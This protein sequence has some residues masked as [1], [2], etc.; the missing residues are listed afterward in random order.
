MHAQVGDWLGVPR[1][2][3]RDTRPA[4]DAGGASDLQ[5]SAQE[6]SHRAAGCWMSLVV[7][8][9]QRSALALH[10]VKLLAGG[11]ALVQPLT[12]PGNQG[13]RRRQHKMSMRAVGPLLSS[14]PGGWTHVCS[15]LS[16]PVPQRVE[17]Q[18]WRLV[19]LGP[20]PRAVPRRPRC[21]VVSQPLERRRLPV[22]VCALCL[23]RVARAGAS[24][25]KAAALRRP[26]RGVWLLCL[27]VCC[28]RSELRRGGAV[29]GVI[30]QAVR[31]NN[32]C[33]PSNQFPGRGRCHRSVRSP[34]WAGSRR[35]TKG[36][37]R[38]GK[39]HFRPGAHW[40]EAQSLC[41]GRGGTP[42]CPGSRLR[43]LGTAM[44]YG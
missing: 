8:C 25:T 17:T 10:R 11:G 32:D 31:T 2:K 6:C 9:G 41:G 23:L 22:Y 43:I 19:N 4:L 20:A 28:A 34:S 13:L 29:S 1:L 3:T 30:C 44:E 15:K 18:S 14:E 16:W 7:R 38:R 36:S 12:G 42:H 39:F 37:C 40:F 35:P 24:R 21:P 26:L 5:H 33:H 27:R